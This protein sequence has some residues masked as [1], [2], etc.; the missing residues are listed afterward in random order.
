MYQRLTGE[1][2]VSRKDG[3]DHNEST[4]T[5]DQMYSKDINISI[6]HGKH[7]AICGSSGSGKSTLKSILL[8]LLETSKGS[9]TIGSQNISLFTQQAV[10]K[11]ITAMPQDA[12]F[13]PRGCGD[14]VREN[15][16][17]LREVADDTEIYNALDKTGS[18]EPIDKIGGLDAQLRQQ[19]SGLLSE[20]QKQLFCL[21]RAMLTRRGGYTLWMR[22]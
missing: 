10:C 17:P 22:L 19:G 5:M 7:I 4:E 14:S 21:A 3:K 13:V 16:D 11:R 1:F 2:H 8:R 18:C 15:L 9:V 12:W 6:P 20:G